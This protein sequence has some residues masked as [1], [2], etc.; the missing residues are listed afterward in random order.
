MRS[1]SYTV[2]GERKTEYT[3]ASF[4]RSSLKFCTVCPRLLAILLLPT[5]RNRQC[6]KKLT[7]C[8]SF[9]LKPFP[10]YWNVDSFA[11]FLLIPRLPLLPRCACI[12]GMVTIS[13][14][15]CMFVCLC[16]GGGSCS[17]SLTS[18]PWKAGGARWPYAA[19]RR[20]MGGPTPVRP[21]TRLAWLSRSYSCTSLV[22]QP[23]P[24]ST[25]EGGGVSVWWGSSSTQHRL[26]FGQRTNYLLRQMG[27]QVFIPQAAGV[28]WTGH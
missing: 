3:G 28:T 12:P 25:Q 18:T 4:P 14:P 23:Q 13:K 27:R 1:T 19:S 11:E 5:G 15:L 2:Y 22:S 21:P 20:T 26:P 7:N 24:S 9:A 8:L 6:K 10:P 16:P 17:R